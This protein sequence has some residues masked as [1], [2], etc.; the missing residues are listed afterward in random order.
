MQ[1]AVADVGHGKEHVPGQFALDTCIPRLGVRNLTWVSAKLTQSASGIEEAAIRELAGSG[2]RNGPAVPLTIAGNVRAKRVY[3]ENTT[4]KAAV[5]DGDLVVT[6]FVRT[7]VQ[8][9]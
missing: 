8:K 2:L 4:Q 1:R 5:V 9:I 6:V 3:V 7:A